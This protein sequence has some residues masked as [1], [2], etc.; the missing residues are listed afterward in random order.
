VLWDYVSM[1]KLESARYLLS[2][3]LIGCATTQPSQAAGPITLAEF[4]DLEE[5]I[6]A[7]REPRALGGS[8]PGQPT[9]SDAMMFDEATDANSLQALPGTS[10]LPEGFE[11]NLESIMFD[12][13]DGGSWLAGRPEVTLGLDIELENVPGT[14]LSSAPELLD[15]TRVFDPN[16]FLQDDGLDLDSVLFD[17]EPNLSA[18]EMFKAPD[19]IVDTLSS[20]GWSGRLIRFTE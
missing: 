19:R 8:T 18:P 13:A 5:T 4:L 10:L 11:P 20:S 2:L 17:L 6:G 1:K 14:M 12:E 3:L 16:T 9:T 7:M 15:P